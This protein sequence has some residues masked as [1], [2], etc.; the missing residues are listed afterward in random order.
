MRTHDPLPGMIGEHPAMRSVYRL[1]RRIAPKRIPVLIV[2]ETGTGKELVARALHTLGPSPGGQFVDL[3]CA[4]LPEGLAEAE[5]FGWERGAFT[6]A[7]QRGIGL[8]ELAHGGTL[9]LDE[10]CSMPVGL[11]AKML[12]ALELQ[13]FRRVGGRELIR[14]T[15]RLVATVA[16]PL[17]A[18]VQAGRLRVDLGHRLAGAEVTLPRLAERVSDIPELAAHFL[19]QEAGEGRAFDPDALEALQSFPWPGN[20]RELRAAVARMAAVVDHAVLRLEDVLGAL[21]RHGGMP[22]RDQVVRL[23]DEVGGSVS[24]AARALGMARSTFRRHLQSL[25]I[26][27]PS[28]NA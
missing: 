1:V 14:T 8:L 5:L 21:P 9:F 16:E 26:V 4:A 6:G 20:V 10:V 23:L 12:R 15:F 19:A 3:N 28:P 17:Q 22:P 13:T 24:G 27:P 18:L 25:E 2:G 7:H 11:Q